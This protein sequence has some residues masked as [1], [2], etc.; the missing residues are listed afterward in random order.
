MIKTAIALMASVQMAMR[1]RELAE[2]RQHEDAAAAAQQQ[3]HTSS[4]LH[5][6]FSE[7]RRRE[8]LNESFQTLR[9]LLPPG[10]K[11]RRD[12]GN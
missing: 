10:T 7:R 9:A 3:Q 1:H 11:V 6:M 5:H 8:R 2:A 12:S 4:Q